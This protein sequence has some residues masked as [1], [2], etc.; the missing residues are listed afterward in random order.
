MMA[1]TA[2]LAAVIVLAV[3]AGCSHGSHG[4]K[5]SGG[6]SSNN[7]NNKQSGNSAMHAGGKNDGGHGGAGAGEPAPYVSLPA[8]DPQMTYRRAMEYCDVQGKV[9]V[10][11]GM[12][13]VR[14]QQMANYDCE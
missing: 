2:K 14:Q 8:L 13:L 6:N 7:N 10:F 11:R 3:L 4:N 1:R 5:S 9:A 12:Q